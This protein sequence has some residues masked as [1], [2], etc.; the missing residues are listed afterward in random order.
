MTIEEINSLGEREFIDFTL[1]QTYEVLR[2]IEKL[3]W[4]KISD[5]NLKENGNF[6][7]KLLDIVDEKVVCDFFPEIATDDA[8]KGHLLLKVLSI[9]TCISQYKILYLKGE[10]ELEILEEVDKVSNAVNDANA[11]MADMK[12]YL[13]KT[14]ED[15]TNTIQGKAQEAVDRI[16]PNLMTTVLTIM[17]IFTA[18]I[19]IIM[20]VVITSNSWLNNA[21]G[22]SAVLAFIVP[23]IVVISSIILLLNVVFSRKKDRIIV[24]PERDWDSS[25]TVA[26]IAK[27]SKRNLIC[28]V[29]FIVAFTAILVVFS[30]YE[31][32]KSDEPHMRYILSPGMYQCTEII[33]ADTE[34]TEVVI[35]FEL[36]QKSYIIPYRDSYFHD[37]NLYFCEEHQ[38]LE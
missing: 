10:V 3:D 21:N 34:K 32:K 23:N 29:C 38:K 16:E 15:F 12:D 6:Y 18:I 26:E 20:S 2:V 17:G 30:L 1:D 7:S 36:N 22:A 11:K 25:R 24:V 31:I 37:G 13:S 14:E 33:N 35:E 8:Q 9:R 4:S 28:T 5:N 19:T 27:K